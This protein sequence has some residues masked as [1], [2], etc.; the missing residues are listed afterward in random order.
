MPA[1]NATTGN[2]PFLASLERLATPVTVR[3]FQDALQNL[4]G[5]PFTPT[6]L[7]QLIYFTEEQQEPVHLRDL[8]ADEP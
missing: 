4:T 8:S 1:D 7:L 3:A 2:S 6:E 5:A